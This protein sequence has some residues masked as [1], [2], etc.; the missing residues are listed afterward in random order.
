MF[1]PAI[2]GVVMF[3]P[4]GRGICFGL[5]CT[6]AEYEVKE[7]CCPMCNPGYYVYRHC[8]EDTS[9]TCAP[10]PA[11]T[12]TD[13]HSGLEACRRC[14]VCD[15]SAGL[16]VKRECSSTSDTLCEPLEGHYC[17]DPIQDGCRGAVEHTKCKP[18]QSIKQTGTT[19]TDTVCIDCDSK[20]F[21]DGTF[22]TCKPHTQCELGYYITKEGTSSSDTEC[23]MLLVPVMIAV[24]LLVVILVVTA[25]TVTAKV[26]IRRRGKRYFHFDQPFSLY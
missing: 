6:P 20:T 11:S 15:S 16:R 7:E 17:T 2:I 12:Y 21:S 19:Y 3:L 10:C 13:A 14:T 25:V 4:G 24:T 22:T 23:Q 1:L 8:T 26:R 18:G 5:T 9:T